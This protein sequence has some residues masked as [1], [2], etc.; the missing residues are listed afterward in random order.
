MIGWTEFVAGVVTAID[1]LAVYSV[2]RVVERPAVLALWTG[3]LH[4]LFPLAGFVIG[5]DIIARYLVGADAFA[6]IFL[7]LMGLQMVLHQSDQGVLRIPA[8][9]LAAVVS[10]DTFSVSLSFGM[11]ELQ[12]SVFLV[13]AGVSATVFAYAALKRRFGRGARLNRL[14]GV[15][16]MI[17]ALLT[18]GND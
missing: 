13:S 4:V 2:Y 11:L 3:A 12:R 18:F 9:L 15:C 16:L 8:P 17:I 5:E 10:V 14:A 7:F 1:V 6:T